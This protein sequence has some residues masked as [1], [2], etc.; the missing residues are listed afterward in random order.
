MATKTTF[1]MPRPGGING[2]S[3]SAADSAE[4]EPAEPERAE[5]EPAEPEPA[6]SGLLGPDDRVDVACREA[7]KPHLQVVLTIADKPKPTARGKSAATV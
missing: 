5:P 7:K 2:A 3:P 4:P 6:E 1:G